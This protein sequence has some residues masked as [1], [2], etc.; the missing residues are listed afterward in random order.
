M[1]FEFFS[2]DNGI[3]FV[4]KNFDSPISYCVLIANT[5]TRDEANSE[6]GYAHFVEHMLFKGTVKRKA[7]QII[8]KIENS[9][10]DINAYTSKEDTC[11]HAT[12]LR[13]D[14]EKAFDLI[15]DI[16]FNSIF[17][18]KE[19]IKERDVIL[20]EINSY[21]DSPAE[22]IFD[23][24]DECIFQD[25]PLGFNILGSKKTLKKV[26]QKDL[27]TFYK[28]KYNTDQI[29]LV[30]FG[31][32]PKRK[33]IR[34]LAEKYFSSIPQNLR[35]FERIIPQQYTPATKKIERSTYQA[36]C[37]MGNKIFGL[38]DQRRTAMFLL[39]NILGGPG[40][41]CRLNMILREKYGCAYNVESSYVPF[42][43]TGLFSVYFGTDKKLL[44]KSFSIVMKELKK[45]QN[46][47]LSVQQLAIAKKQMK[48]QI[49][50]SH[51]S[52]E[53]LVLGIAK[54]FL[55]FNKMDSLEEAY[56]SINRIDANQ[57]I[58]IAQV[59]FD[60]KQLSSLIYA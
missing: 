24:F 4:H 51:E 38:T 11:V 17:P 45:L 8:N 23:E 32:L 20:D 15:S 29:V 39:N 34:Y 7:H 5:G 25:H 50:I 9:G 47:K 26:N 44:E 43:D 46:E 21:K 35:N 19:I 54:S 37:I 56:E 12:L 52:K 59:V 16:I 10:G 49:A 14:Y 60:E 3:R 30:Y 48:G 55:H 31:Y 40:L 41:N 6:Q 18:E 53:N 58:E 42:T 36:H 1:D 28:G 22:L 33:N 13:D 2:L 57:I 27:L